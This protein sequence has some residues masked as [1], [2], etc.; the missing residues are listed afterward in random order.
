MSIPPI[1][2]LAVF[3]LGCNVSP[4]YCDAADSSTVSARTSHNAA[5]PSPIKN[6]LMQISRRYQPSQRVLGHLWGEPRSA[7]AELEPTPVSVYIVPT[8]RI[9]SPSPEGFN[10]CLPEQGCSSVSYDKGL[11]WQH[12][13]FVLAAEYL[14]PDVH[15]PSRNLRFSPVSF[16][17]CARFYSQDLQQRAPNII[18][19][20][21][22]CAIRL[23]SDSE[24]ASELSAMST[25]ELT[26]FERM[27]DYLR[28]GFGDSDNYRSH[29]PRVRLPPAER[30]FPDERWCTPTN[31]QVRPKCRASMVLHLDSTDRKLT[32]II[33]TPRLYEVALALRENNVVGDPLNPL[34]HGDRYVPPSCGGFLE[35]H[36]IERFIPTSLEAFSVSG[37]STA[38]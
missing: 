13:P 34:L 32:A 23:V 25:D 27:F 35:C 12:R 38:R 18:A 30:V 19:L 36:P 3:I 2:W 20:M 1:T 14:G 31:G 29:A 5:A 9:R 6:S 8:A 28:T 4:A 16:I 15:L 26:K 24:S 10:K 17:F 21:R 22:F 11:D 7:F 37:T 33:A